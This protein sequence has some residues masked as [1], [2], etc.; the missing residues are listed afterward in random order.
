[1][2][3]ESQKWDAKRAARLKNLLIHEFGT[4]PDAFLVLSGLVLA[5][6]QKPLGWVKKA[7]TTIGLQHQ[8]TY[9]LLALAKLLPNGES[10]TGAE[11]QRLV[12]KIQT[13]QTDGVGQQLHRWLRGGDGR[14]MSDQWQ[15]RLAWLL[16]LER[17]VFLE[18]ITAPEETPEAATKPASKSAP[19]KAEIWTADLLA[20]ELMFP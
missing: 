16:G 15:D 11:L 19:A 5:A 18:K 17:E 4:I 7:K 3:F 13:D 8:R 20:T 6:P 2:Q 9:K 12:D 14:A 10:A 1:M